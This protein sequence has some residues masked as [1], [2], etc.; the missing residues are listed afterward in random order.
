MP[1]SPRRWRARVLARMRHLPVALVRPRRGR[2]AR[3]LARCFQLQRATRSQ[4]RVLCVLFAMCRNIVH[5]AVCDVSRHP[6]AK[7][8]LGR[9]ESWDSTARRHASTATLPS[10]SVEFSALP[11]KMLLPVGNFLPRLG[12][13]CDARRMRLGLAQLDGPTGRGRGRSGE[14]CRR[15]RVIP[16]AFLR[17]NP[18]SPGR[19]SSARLPKRN[20]SG[21]RV[22]ARPFCA[23]SARLDP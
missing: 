20:C 1:L 5:R 8:L 22:P 19:P 23:S 11:G 12:V 15:Q 18:P 17:L 9:A 7:P 13:S 21:Y 10:P 4:H 3:S 14:P 6:A 2:P 16:L